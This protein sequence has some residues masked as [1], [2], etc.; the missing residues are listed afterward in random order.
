MRI[1]DRVHHVKDIQQPGHFQATMDRGSALDEDDDRQRLAVVQKHAYPGRIEIWA[2]IE[3][4]YYD[5]LGSQ[6]CN[7]FVEM[8]CARDIDVADDM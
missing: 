7:R 5:L 2:H 8:V 3:I 4:D 1:F 6:Q